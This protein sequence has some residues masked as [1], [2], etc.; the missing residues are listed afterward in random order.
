MGLPTVAGGLAGAKIGHGR[1]WWSLAD[2]RGHC[3]EIFMSIFVLLS[4][5][6][7]MWEEI[8]HSR[9]A[10]MAKAKVGQPSERDGSVTAVR[11]DTNA[12]HVVAKPLLSIEAT[13]NLLG[14]SRSTLYRAISSGRFP[15]PVY[16]IGGRMRIPRRAVERLIEAV[17]T[18]D[19]DDD[20]YRWEEGDTYVWD[21][22]KK[23]STRARVHVS[24]PG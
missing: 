15:L 14:G 2:N 9:E 22:A 3:P 7:Y 4:A 21:P 6:L 23:R 17:P 1:H 19:T 12:G 24:G 8:S 16:A 5:Y 10:Q 11:R 20:D 13:A 18:A